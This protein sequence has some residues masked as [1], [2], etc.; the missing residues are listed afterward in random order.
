MF[1]SLSSRKVVENPLNGVMEK[2]RQKCQMLAYDTLGAILFFQCQYPQQSDINFSN[3]S[4]ASI[5][6][7]PYVSYLLNKK[8]KKSVKY[9]YNISNS[10]V[11]SHLHEYLI[12]SIIFVQES[13]SSKVAFASFFFSLT[14][15]IYTTYDIK[16]R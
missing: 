13:L 1:H 9:I 11:L 4:F 6:L 8:K 7:F 15:N 2:P 14:N 3:H 5:F 12:V 10:T 16:E